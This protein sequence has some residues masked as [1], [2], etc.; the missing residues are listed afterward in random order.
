MILPA[1]RRGPSLPASEGHLTEE[2]VNDFVD[3]LM[4]AAVHASLTEHLAA[5]AECRAEIAE[6][7]ELVGIAR[8]DATLVVAPPEL[9]IVVLATTIHERFVRRE[10][11]RRLGLPLAMFFFAFVLTTITLTGWILL[12]CPKTP[13]HRESVAQCSEP[14]YFVVRSAARERYKEVRDDQRDAVRNLGKII[15]Q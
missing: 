8:A 9:E 14:W 5:C 2:Q 3:G 10:I 11:A 4:T 6:L 13:G 1:N 7:S 12:A 15:R